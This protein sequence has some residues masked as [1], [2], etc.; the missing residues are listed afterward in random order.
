ME[1][2]KLFLID[3]KIGADDKYIFDLI[4]DFS[5]KSSVF[6]G[7]DAPLSYNINGDDRKSDSLLRRFLKEKNIKSS[8]VMT[9]TMT[10]MSYLTLRGISIS[11]NLESLKNKPKIIEVH[12]FVSLQINGANT[13]DIDNVKK[14]L[15]PKKIFFN[16][17]K[18]FQFLVYLQ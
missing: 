8:S 5:Q 7:I 4:K 3:Y 1:K 18:K 13:Y 9:P 16:I 14:I 6:I 2:N 12:P 10:R 15:K 11:R 17:L